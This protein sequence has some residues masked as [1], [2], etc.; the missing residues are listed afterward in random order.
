MTTDD[1]KTASAD[2]V[3]PLSPL[4]RALWHDAHG[5][6]D[7]AHR[8]AQDV[9]DDNGAW[10]HA[11][12]HRKEGDLDNAAYWYGRAKQPVPTDALEAEWERLA[13]RLLH[14]SA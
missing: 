9:D 12:L 7:S 13:L 10:V 2:A 6:W 8:L 14:S 5:D 3:R 4:L 1:L 11:Y